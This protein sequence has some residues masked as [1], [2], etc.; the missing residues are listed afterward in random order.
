MI[1]TN[2]NHLPAGLQVGFGRH[3][4]RTAGSTLIVRRHHITIMTPLLAI[5]EQR[6]YTVIAVIVIIATGFAKIFTGGASFAAR[7]R[8]DLRRLERKLD[9][10]L[11][12]QGIELPSEAEILAKDP[13]QKIAAIKL[14][15]EENPGV[16][17]TEAKARVEEICKRSQ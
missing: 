5:L 3:N 8:L 16:G 17:L 12:H 14:Y 4:I 13:T 11:K 2:Q 15:R 10:L 1:F 7:Q 6:D 9:A